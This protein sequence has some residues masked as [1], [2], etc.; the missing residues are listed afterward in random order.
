[1][2]KYL[3]IISLV[4]FVSFDSFS[5]VKTKGKVKVNIKKEAK[6]LEKQGWES[7]TT[8]PL[9]A[10]YE[11]V[12]LDTDE[13][14][15][16]GEIVNIVGEGEFTSNSRSIAMQSAATLAKNNIGGQMET[17]IKSV[18]KIDQVNDRIAQSLEEAVIVTTALVS[19]KITGRPI[20]SICREDKNGNY[21]CRVT[22]SF[23][24]EK[25]AKLHLQLMRDELNKEKAQD[26]RDEYENFFKE[27]LYDNVK[28]DLSKQ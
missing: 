9:A 10:Q 24:F 13:Q 28:S 6:D 16:E 3:L 25:A 2:N 26:V 11:R 7:T 27:G 22:Y 12:I 19:Q 4:F 15:D 14:D 17:S 8:Y 21:N 1:M 23:N 18:T 5:Q 20:M